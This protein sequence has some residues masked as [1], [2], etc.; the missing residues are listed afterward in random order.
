MKSPW[1]VTFTEQKDHWLLRWKKPHIGSENVKSYMVRVV[2]DLGVPR[3][4]LVDGTKTKVKLKWLNRTS[5]YHA[6]VV[7]QYKDGV[8]ETSLSVPL[9]VAQRGKRDMKTYI[10]P[11]T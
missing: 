9:L 5:T 10:D 8:E 4:V 3:Q 2:D 1:M 11:K 7:A 6:E